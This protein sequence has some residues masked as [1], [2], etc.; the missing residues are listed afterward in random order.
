MRQPEDAAFVDQAKAVDVRRFA[1]AESDGVGQRIGHVHDQRVVAVQDAHGFIAKDA[2][3]VGSIGGHVAMPVQVVLRQVQ[4]RGRI[5]LQ[6]E[7]RVQLEAGQFQDPR[8][9]QGT[10][11]GFGR[12]SVCIHGLR[13]R[14]GIEHFTQHVECGR[15]D[16][17]GHARGQAR[18]FAQQ[19]YQ[20]GDGRLAIRARDRDDFRRIAAFRLER[21]QRLREQ[22]DLAPHGDIFFLR[23]RGNCR[24]FAARRQARAD[25]DEIDAIEQIGREGAGDE[26][27]LRHGGLQRGQALGRLTRV[28]H[29]H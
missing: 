4:D 15:A 14:L 11:G 1:R 21:G 12:F 28:G 7:R 8:L 20:A 27:R 2:R 13:R 10:G 9:R 29:A 24:Q 25:R 3:L 6:A 17:A 23:G 5:G 18:A 19:A 16:I 26:L 22:F